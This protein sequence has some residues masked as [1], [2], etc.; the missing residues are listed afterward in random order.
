MYYRRKKR[1]CEDALKKIW[2]KGR[3]W[4]AT[5]ITGEKWARIEFFTP[6]KITNDEITKF[7][8]N[9][10]QRPFFTIKVLP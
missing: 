2:V 1:W 3:G 8:T 5:R 10:A 9:K 4:D 7:W 6:V